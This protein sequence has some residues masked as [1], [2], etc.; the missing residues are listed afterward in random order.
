MKHLPFII[1]LALAGQAAADSPEYTTF[2]RQHQQETG[3]VWDMPVDLIGEAMSPMNVE[4]GGSL[5][6]LWAIRSSPITDYLLDQKLVG[7]YLPRATTAVITED[8]SP[9]VPRTRADRPFVLRIEISGLLQGPSIPDAAARVLLDRHAENYPDGSTSLTL[10]EAFAHDPVE[11]T[12]IDTNGTS[13]FSFQLTALQGPDPTKV[14]GE[15]HFIIHALPDDDVTQTQIGSAMIRI[16]PVADGKISGIEDGQRVRTSTPE[17][18]L[19][20]NDL[21]PRSDTYLL[22]HK[23]GP[24]SQATGEKVEGSVL[25][26][27]Q[28]IPEARTLT[29]ADWGTALTADGIHT[30]ELLT[31]TPFGIDRLDSVTF[32]VDR[33]LEVRSM[34]AGMGN[35]TPTAEGTP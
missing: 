11:S 18:T 23:G 20:L 28:D 3:V 33:V 21:Y 31:E 24:V 30:L 9:G 8:P 19:T 10:D 5:F 15:E 25:I 34:L 7:A 16:W 4:L 32:V 27:D 22:L 2:I 14:S 13:T 12:Y 1:L 6:Q 17:I 35:P 29:I 26:L